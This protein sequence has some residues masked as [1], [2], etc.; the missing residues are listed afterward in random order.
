[1][2]FSSKDRIDE[3]DFREKCSKS[4][5]KGYNVHYITKEE[6]EAAQLAGSREDEKAMDQGSFEAAQPRDKA[7]QE[8]TAPPSAEYGKLN[9]DDPVTREQIEK[10][11]GE[12][13]EWLQETIQESKN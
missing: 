8:D 2:K 4:I 11:L 9:E 6:L 3:R 1:M 10:I 12:K 13:E 7:L 5:V